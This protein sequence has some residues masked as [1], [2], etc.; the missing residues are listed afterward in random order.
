MRILWHSNAPWAKSGYGTQ[1]AIWVPRLAALGHEIAISAFHGLQSGPM[2]WQG[3]TVYP[4]GDSPY[5]G[6]IIGMHARHFKADL[7]IMLMDEWACPGDTMHGLK[8]ACWMPVDCTPLSQFDY[9][10]L[11]EGH[12][13]WPLP[14]TRFGERQ[15][16]EAGWD[17]TDGYRRAPMYVPH[18]IDTTVFRPPDDRKALREAMGVDDKFVIFMNSANLDKQRKGYPETFA[19][20]SRFHVKHPDTMLVIHAKENHPSGLDLPKTAARMGCADAIKFNSQYLIAAGLVEPEQLRGSYGM[21]DVYINASLGEGFGLGPLEAMACGIPTIVADNSAQP[22]VQGSAGWKVKCEK[23]W[24][25]GHQSWWG[26]PLIDDIARKL[27][28]AYR[29]D[30]S[31]FA[32]KSAAREQALKYDADHVLAE[33]WKPALERLETWVGS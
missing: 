30:G 7:I 15:L 26:R 11:S 10:R 4:A 2:E 19:A 20:F 25:A 27:E 5:G 29:R 8:V 21:A 1:T 17:G 9:D 32:K 31:Y 28:L 23:A 16:R 13:P 3:H 22:E 24:A 18:G 6:D 12:H 33:Y 14:L